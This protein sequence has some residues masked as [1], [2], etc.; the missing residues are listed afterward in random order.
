MTPEP[1]TKE[2]S[3]DLLLE[4][5]DKAGIEHGVCGGR[6]LPAA[7]GRGT[8]N[9]E[10][11]GLGK[12]YAGRFT[13]FAAIDLTA[14]TA[15]VSEI[16]KCIKEMGFK[17]IAL[18]PSSWNLDID[19]RRLYPVYETS[20]ALHIPVMFTLSALLGRELSY[21][22]PEHL[23]RL[24]ADFPNLTLISAH[25]NYP[26][27]QEVCGV[28]WKRRNVYLIPDVYAVNFPG[29]LDYVHAANTFA[30]DKI[31]FGTA[32]PLQPLKEYVDLFV[33]LPFK[34]DRIREK[35][36]GENAAALLG[37]SLK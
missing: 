14:T 30:E 35:V 21:N 18:E 6:L 36:L 11:I 31:L 24:A 7:S 10:I 13:P 26:Y 15:A 9:S 28:V 12:D 34:T 5:M 2:G 25:G 32:Y 29:H 20:Q 22:N 3:M 27:S 33:K 17:G 16:E 23:D 4:E 8:I 37:L 19:D 1:S